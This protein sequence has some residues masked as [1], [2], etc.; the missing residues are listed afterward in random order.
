ME[1]VYHGHSCVQ[2]SDGEQSLIIDPFLFGKSTQCDTSRK[3]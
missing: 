2:I 1:I 3:Y